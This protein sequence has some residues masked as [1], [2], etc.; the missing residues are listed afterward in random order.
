MKFAP[1]TKYLAIAVSIALLAQ[2]VLAFLP[3]QTFTGLP[4]TDED[5]RVAAELSN[6]SG[7]TAENIL[8]IKQTGISWNEVSEQL[9]NFNPDAVQDTAERLSLLNETGI[10]E[11]LLE[12]LHGQGYADEEI[13]DAKL[14]AERII[15]QLQQVQNHE[16]RVAI[17]EAAITGE[18]VEAAEFQA[19]IVKISSAF[20]VR[21]AVPLLLELKEEFGSLDAVMNEYL[22]ALQLDLVLKTYLTDKEAYLTSRAEQTAGVPESEL[23]TMELLEKAALAQLQ[24]KPAENDADLADVAANSLNTG[25]ENT[26]SPLPEIKPPVPGNV[27]PQNPAEAIRQEIEAINPNRR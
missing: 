20:A 27:I 21:E 17:P 12:Q 9:K 1:K 4:S 24:P 11:E 7:V 6:L 3:K 23:V 14:L 5:L 19:A 22:L 13:M 16:A 26:D 18:A 10:G 8:K 2:L 25:A 15:F